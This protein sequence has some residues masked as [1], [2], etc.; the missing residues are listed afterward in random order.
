[1]I[2]IPTGPVP[3]NTARTIS[4]LLGV[5]SIAASFFLPAHVETVRRVGEALAL[6]GLT[7]G[8]Q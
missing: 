7:L 4:F 5:A 2:R 1:M 8:K 6:L 3:Q